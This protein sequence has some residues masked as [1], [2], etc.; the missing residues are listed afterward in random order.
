MKTDDLIAA[1]SADVAPV[2]PRAVA[3]RL[4]FGLAAGIA[5]SAIIMML[6]L[7]PRPD[8]MPATH[9]MP[10]WMKFFYALTIAAFGF[11]LV[12]RLAR[13]GGVAGT[14]AL[15]LLAPVAFMAAMALYRLM[16]APP[17]ARMPMMMGQSARVCARNIVI[18]S[19]PVFVGLFWGLRRL[20]PTRLMLAGAVAGVLAGAAG[21]FIYEFH[22]TES[23]AAFVAIWYTLGIALMGA[24]GA[25][26]GRALL[27][28]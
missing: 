11:A 26:L 16:E 21:T 3:L 22:C 19:L 13:P 7:G 1:L 9:T 6:W 2:R 12:D 17:D 27:R 25:A 8:L 10:F 4:A 18:L 15:L 5:V 28:W 23:T 14:L 20:A 24:L